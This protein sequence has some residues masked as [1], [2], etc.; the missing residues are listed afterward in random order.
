MIDY[1][2]TG[3]D[4]NY[5]YYSNVSE[6][7][8][9]EG[10]EEIYIKILNKRNVFSVKILN[11][12]IKIKKI[13]LNKIMILSESQPEEQVLFSLY[14]TISKNSDEIKKLKNMQDN[15]NIN[16]IKN[17]ITIKGNSDNNLINSNIN[18]K[19]DNINKN[20]IKNI[21]DDPLSGDT[22]FR[23]NNDNTSD[24]NQLI[25]NNDVI[26]IPNNNNTNIDEDDKEELAFKKDLNLDAEV[27]VGLPP[28]ALKIKWFYLL[29]T[30]IG[31]AYIIIFLVGIFNS[32][33]G[34]N[35]FIFSLFLIGVEI[36]ITGALGFV[37]INKRIFNNIAVIIL[38]FIALFAGIVG[39]IIVNLNEKT[40][41]YFNISLIFG[42]IS[43]CFSLLCLFWTNKLR[44]NVLINR[45]Q[46]AEKLV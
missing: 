12:E 33:V 20:N 9:E 10:D 37:K 32:E 46:K 42:I 13:S 29:L 5:E 43:F 38:T 17:D 3:E 30:I 26:N 35:L 6:V 31:I 1:K 22:P 40:E 4:K 14:K 28:E 25:I 36:F 11:K 15:N 21:S 2:K 44:K 8:S 41:R 19:S 24:N 45:A 39:A 23:K 7:E 34:L 18:N 16:F 27:L